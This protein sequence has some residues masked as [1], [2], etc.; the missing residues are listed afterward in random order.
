MNIRMETVSAF[1][2][3]VEYGSFSAAARVLNKTQAAISLSI[4]TLEVDLGVQLFDRSGKYPKLTEKGENFLK[5][6]KIMMSQYQTFLERSV[7]VYNSTDVKIR[8]GIDPLFCDH[9]IIQTIKELTASLPNI[10]LMI[11][12]QNSVRLA[13]EIQSKNLDIAL[14]M[15]EN[16]NRLNFEYVSAFGI[17]VSWVATRHYI[18][19]HNNGSNILNYHDFCEQRVLLPVAMEAWPLQHVKSALQI[20]HVEDIHTNLSLCR[21]SIGISCLP[22][23]VLEHDLKNGNL[24][25]IELPFLE[26]NAGYW[27]SSI[28]YLSGSQLSP[29]VTWLVEKITKFNS[30]I[31]LEIEDEV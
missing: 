31:N 6:A 30:I 1:I 15:F 14:G 7:A 9:R 27:P 22:D 16:E 4:Q 25:K 10:E 3:A 28:I 18:E 26:K 19:Q 17:D 5:N 20:W 29:A 24:E 13:Q 11:M 21:E 2:A 8:L 12:Q 23:F